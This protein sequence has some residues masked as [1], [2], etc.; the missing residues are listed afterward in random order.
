MTHR[1]PYQFLILTLSCL[2]WSC[3]GLSS[4]PLSQIQPAAQVAF[5]TGKKAVDASRPISGSEEY[6]IG[7]AVCARILAAYPLYDSVK[8]TDYINTLG[9]ALVKH[10]PRPRT[11]KG[12]HFAVL[13]S[14]EP[15][16]FACPG[17]IILVTRGLIRICGSEDALA[18]VLAHEIAHVS[19]QDGIHAISQARWT[20]V[21][22][23]L[24]TETAKQYGGVGGQL[25]QLFE[26]SIDD[27]F[28][29]LVV[30]G[31]SR[32]AEEKADRTAIDILKKAG[33][34]PDALCSVLSKMA[35][36]EKS[37]AGIF[38]TH[39]PAAGRLAHLK[40]VPRA[41]AGKSEKQRALRF[42]KVFG[43]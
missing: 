15:N 29:T 14:D 7:R 39:P 4:L 31:Y 16:A 10:G 28:K 43:A 8:I 26:G 5:K 27:V 32:T 41:G 18:A 35:G 21:L 25:V 2:F 30:N 34:R 37:G 20:Q 24:G 12:Y 33:F 42:K 13:N 40:D 3:S 11:H 38:R 9:Q 36:R 22:T 17:G 1:C 19:H 23:T 6:F